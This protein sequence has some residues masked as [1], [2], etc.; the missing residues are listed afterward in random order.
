MTYLTHRHRLDRKR[1]SDVPWSQILVLDL[2]LDWDLPRCLDGAGAD[3]LEADGDAGEARDRRGRQVREAG[4][5]GLQ[6][7]LVQ[8]G[9]RL[10]D[11][12]VKGLDRVPGLV[13][14][15]GEGRGRGVGARHEHELQKCVTSS[16]SQSLFR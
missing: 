5:R 9:K 11:D 1:E 14:G 12:R 6:V 13:R 15:L 16:P 10:R 3:S 8:L 2:D 4:H 7:R